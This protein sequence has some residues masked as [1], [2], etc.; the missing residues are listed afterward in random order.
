VAERGKDFALYR[1]V[2][3]STNRA[4][5]T[6]FKTNQFTLL[7]NNLH[8]FEDGQWK[9]SEDVIESFPD[10]A[11]ARRGP[12]KAIFSPTLDAEAVFDLQTSEGQRLRGGLR[13]LR[14]TDRASGQSVTVAT[15]KPKAP[16]ELVP[17]HQVVCRSGFDGLDADVV[18]DWTHAAFSQSVVLKEQPALPAGMDPKSVVLEVVTEL[19]AAPAPTLHR[20][21]WPVA[22]QPDVVDDVTIALGPVVIV[23]GHAFAAGGGQTVSVGAQNLG[24][25]APCPCASNGPRRR[26]GGCFWWNRS[27]GVI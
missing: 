22:S 18:L 17:P 3:A 27:H 11:V 4:G 26:T 6:V 8:Y 20:Q 25:A 19:V 24:T 13:A 5:Q 12:T 7:E 14:L 15:V 2:N 21:V 9:P 1:K 23:Q 16:M 10:G